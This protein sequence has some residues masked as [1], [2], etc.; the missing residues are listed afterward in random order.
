MSALL[1]LKRLWLDRDKNAKQAWQRLMEQAQ[2]QTNES[3]DYCV[4]IWDTLRNQ[5]VATGAF[6]DN[7]IKCLAVDEEYQSE[8]LLIQI[9]MHLLEQL[10][11]NGVEHYF[12][13]TKPTNQRMF[14]SLGFELVAKTEHI[15]FMEQGR[16]K[17]SDYEQLL[18]LY[19]QEGVASAI[20]MNANPFTKGHQYLVETAAKTSELV[21]VFVL[22]D[23]RSEFSADDRFA[24]VQLGVAHLSNV[25]VLPSREYMVS[26]STF[27]SYFLRDKAE[28]AIARTQA[29][30][31]ATLFK[32]RIAPILNIQKR[33][34]GE[35]PYSP[36]TEVYNESMQAVFQG[37]IELIIVPRIAVEDEIVSATKVRKAIQAGDEALLKRLLPSTS[38]DY[39]IVHQLNQQKNIL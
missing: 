31:D 22:S 36:V 4:G 6:S 24:M 11:H 27:P 13:Y 5:I 35:E 14:E 15:S 17:F 29:Q 32:E 28:L 38:Y 8:N 34:V 3:I 7:I 9:I 21:Y 26:S 23:D 18:N 16:P 2:L 33:Y 30:L 39:I 37:S 20:V 1:E 19:K 10:K 12:L 25:V